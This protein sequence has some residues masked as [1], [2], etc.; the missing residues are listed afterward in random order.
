MKITL[1]QLEICNDIQ[2]NVDNALRMINEA[3]IKQKPDFILLPG[4]FMGVPDKNNC[5]AFYSKTE[6]V[7]KKLSIAAKSLC[8]N[9]ISG[10]MLEYIDKNINTVSYM[11]DANGVI[12]G[13]V[14]KIYDDKNTTHAMD[15]P[16]FNTA[17]GK[18]AIVLDT[19][20]WSIEIPRIA[21][22]KGA[23]II[24]VPGAAF[25]W[26]YKQKMDNIWG[27]SVLNCISIAYCSPVAKGKFFGGS[28]FVTP[29]KQVAS[30]DVNPF[31]LE[32]SINDDEIIKLREPDMS[33]SKTLWWV[34][35][36]RRPELYKKI[37]GD[38]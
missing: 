25:E 24:F 35:W 32:A 1:L 36:G 30:T 17:F 38:D 21:A 9:I 19:D 3:A 37:I 12:N 16:I 10:T 5:A 13:K 15:F 31:M 23:Q 28:T 33:F 11:I 18:A 2:Q 26:N 34:L 27:I 6:N 29:L 4:F 7:I 22:L 8:V 20:L 14:S